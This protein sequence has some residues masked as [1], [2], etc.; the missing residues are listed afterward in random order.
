[1]VIGYHL[2]LAARGFWLPNDP[3]G[4]WSSYVWAKNLQ[5]FG[6]ATK[7]ST[8]RSVAGTKHDRRARLA[9]KDAMK[10]PAVQFTG[11]QAKA[12]IDGF[13]S[14]VNQLKLTVHAC[15]ILPD[16]VHLVLGRRRRDS[17]EIA[18]MLKRAGTRRLNK[19]G[20]NPMASFKQ[21]NG[22]TPNPWAAGGW[23]VYIDSVRQ[24]RHTIGYVEL[25]P[26][27]AGLRRQQWRF[28]TPFV[29]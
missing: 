10:Y 26:E 21:P 15:S 7:I 1:M 27:K 25:N 17:E 20:I 4:S 2:I 11:L 22:R 8:T 18:E 24:M 16:H 29:E 6:P 3:R 12:I 14:L 23:I 19:A 5:R 28:V 13:D 9:A